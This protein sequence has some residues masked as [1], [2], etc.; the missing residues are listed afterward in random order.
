MQKVD[1][2][3]E[4]VARSKRRH[5]LK[6]SDIG[7]PPERDDKLWRAGKSSVAVF[8]RK[9]F[10]HL[11]YRPLDG[12]LRASAD[13]MERCIRDGGMFV[14]ALPR[15]SG[16]TTLSLIAALWAVLYGHRRFVVI[17]AASDALAQQLMSD[18]Q[19]ELTENEMLFRGFPN[20]ILPFRALE[21]RRQRAGYQTYKGELT[22]LVIRKEM[23]QFAM[24]PEHDAAGSVIRAVGLTSAVRGLRVGGLRPD[25]ILIDDPQTDE[26]AASP[27]QTEMRERLI[28]GTLLGLGGHDVSISCVMNAT[29]IRPN[30]LSDLFLNPDRHPEF[31][32]QKMGIFIQLPKRMDM[33]E[34]YCRLWRQDVR[35]GRLDAP[36]AKSYYRQ[37]RNE[38]EDGAVPFSKHLFAEG[39][40]SAI[41]HAMILRAKL[42][43]EAWQAEYMNAPITKSASV[44]QI[45]PE[46]VR[47]RTNGLE[48]WEIPANCE[49]ITAFSDVN[50]L[51]MCWV[52]VAWGKDGSGYILDYGS[53]PERGELFPENATDV[54]QRTAIAHGI[55]TLAERLSGLRLVRGTFPMT[56]RACGVDRGWHPDVV[57]T[58]T[59][60][61]RAPFPML[62]C[63]GF[64]AAQY[65]P[66]GKNVVGRPGYWCHM[67]EAPRTGQYL[68]VCVDFFKEVIQR[69]F[70][71]EPGTPG[72]ITLWGRNATVHTEFAAHICA[73][74]LEDKAFGA[75][76][77]LWRWRTT[78]R[79]DWFDA[80]VGAAALRAWLA[81]EPAVETLSDGK[82]ETQTQTKKE[83]RKCRT[84]IDEDVL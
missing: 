39:E 75:K 11:C 14:Q 80:I 17:V 24:R 57:H 8:A 27:T 81:G 18:V 73:E 26:S 36:N 9:L 13:T 63:R 30:D 78:G 12:G 51:G 56:I 70:M 54:Q 16:K 41:E 5:V 66:T 37:N 40:M 20:A 42:G 45:S 3:R 69:G 74:I 50:R 53:I 21:G 1:K 25:L 22:G 48:R 60:V 31:M 77:P 47:T 83:A 67:T 43:D 15:G 46:L 4:I 35:E 52:L 62:P 59:R 82:T 19:K 84:P 38:M 65:N 6:A 64:P 33:W 32:R 49:I 23:I 44:V 2:K 28:M 72:S 55:R 68:A 7:E 71:S 58:T 29:I 76:G 10:P 34:E 79:N 61:V